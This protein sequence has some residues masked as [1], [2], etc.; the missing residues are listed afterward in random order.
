MSKQSVPLAVIDDPVS[1]ILRRLQGAESVRC[2]H[3]VEVQ[4]RAVNLFCHGYLDEDSEGEVL[5][6]VSR[7]IRMS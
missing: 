1:H 2:S 5:G 7:F 4:I 6:R 3:R